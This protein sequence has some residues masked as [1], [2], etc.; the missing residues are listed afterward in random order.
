MAKPIEENPI[1]K[2]KAAKQFKEMFLTKTAPSPERIER[3][4]K[5]V[6]TYQSAMVD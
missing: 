1:I 3:N 2:G 4:K 6:E 5:D